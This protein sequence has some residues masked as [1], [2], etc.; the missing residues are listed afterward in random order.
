MLNTV[1]ATSKLNKNWKIH[2]IEDNQADIELINELLLDSSLNSPKISSSKKLQDGLDYLQ[3][4]K[5]DLILLDLSLPDCTGYKTVE[6]IKLIVPDVPVIILT[7]SSLQ[8][9]LLRQCIS[10]SET[11]LVKGEIDSDSLVSAITRAIQSKYNF[12]NTIK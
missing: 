4:N 12:N 7:G 6:K 1:E 5:V 11:Y 8:R 2:Y 3:K 9:E 10:S